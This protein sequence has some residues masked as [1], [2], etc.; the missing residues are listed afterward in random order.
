VKKLFTIVLSIAVV[1]V[2]LGLLLQ[3]SRIAAQEEPPQLTLSDA[4]HA[5][6][7]FPTVAGA[8]AHAEV[9]ALSGPLLYNGGPVMTGT[10]TTYAIFWLPASG[11]L[12]NG[13]ATSMSAH[14]QTV[15]KN[16]L[17]DYP[18][19]GIDNNNTQYY[20]IVGTVKTY[21]QNKGSLGGSYVDTSAYPASGCSDSATPGNCIT[22]AQIQAEIQNV[23][24]LKGWTGAINKMFLLFTSSGEGSCFDS[25]STSCAYVQY[26]AYHGY[27]LSGTTPVIYGNEPYGNTSACQAPGTPSPNSD[28][29]A[30]TAATAA[31]HEL[32]EAIT[33]PELNAW[34]TSSGYEIGDLCAYNYGTNTWDSAKA[35]QMWNGRFYE[36]QREYDNHTGG[37]VQVGP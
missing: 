33:D 12:Q 2:E 19:H 22:D 28:P 4:E 7:I 30:D 8:S 3:G 29:V 34:Y 15:Q 13:S 27:F 24:T 31:S 37:C 11:K 16:L 26:C 23:M 20:Q 18:A 21:L 14:Y 9:A 5:V 25:S 10:V 35:N 17:G 36:L 6:H 32:T 1:A